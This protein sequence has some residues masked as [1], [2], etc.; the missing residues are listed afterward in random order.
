MLKHTFLH[1]PRVGKATEQRLWLSGIRTWEDAAACSDTR[2]L[3]SAAE[4][5][6][7][8]LDLSYR[9]LER[10]EIEF[11]GD[12]LPAAEAWRLYAN[13]NNPQIALRTAFLDIETTGM[14][15]LYSQL[16]VIGLSDGARFKYYLQGENLE[17][18]YQEIE[19]YDLLVTFNGKCFDIPYLKAA[20]PGLRLPRAH[21]D[22]RYV[23]RKLKLSGGLKAI[24]RTTGHARNQDEL[25]LLDGFDAV[26]LWRLYRRGVPAALDTLLRYNAEDVVGLKPL[27]EYACNR[28]VAELPLELAP[29]PVAERVTLD[30]PYSPDLIRS[31]KSA[32]L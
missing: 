21:I 9:A 3:G 11:F 30:I 16:T 2:R 17:D 13:F 29:M 25:S 19:N 18:F 14:N 26:V 22:L 4:M 8:Y 10:H 5:I 27:L 20:L 32:S 31:I 24:E 28:L 23:L 12:L 1:I 7:W 15:P 6:K